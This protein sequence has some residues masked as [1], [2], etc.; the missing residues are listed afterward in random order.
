MSREKTLASPTLVIIRGIP[1]GGKSYITKFLVDTLGLQHTL[2]LDPDQIDQKSS[3]Y[4][5]FSKKLDSEG[6]DKKFHL[7][8]FSRQQAYDATVQKKITIW[9]QAFMDFDGLALT[10]RRI[11]DVAKE[12]QLTLKTLIV[13]VEIDP[14]I[15]KTRIADRKAHG[16]HDVPNEAL[17]QFIERYESFEG[18]DYPVI[19]VNGADD[20]EKSVTAIVSSLRNL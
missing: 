1:G 7:Y 19:R 6:V 15:A 18:R 17:A 3:N 20:K 16:G 10:I 12:H 13:E 8:R 9:N 11:E 2:T 5:D 14:E 4:I